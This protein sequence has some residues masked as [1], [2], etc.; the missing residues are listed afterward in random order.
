MRSGWM[1]R[2]W[3]NPY[4]A[5]VV[6]TLG[7]GGTP[8]GTISSSGFRWIKHVDLSLGYDEGGFGASVGL[9]SFVDDFALSSSHGHTPRVNRI[10]NITSFNVLGAAFGSLLALLVTDRNGRIRSW[11]FGGLLWASGLLIQIFSSDIYGLMLFAR[12]WS[13]L[14]AGLLT[15][16]T[17]LYLSEVAP[18]RTRGSVTNLYMVNLLLFLMIGRSS[19]YSPTFLRSFSFLTTTSHVRFLHQLRCTDAHDAH[20]ETISSRPSHP[21]YPDGHRILLFLLCPRNTALSHLQKTVRRRS[22]RLGATPRQIHLRSQR[23]AGSETHVLASSGKDRPRRAVELGRVQ[24]K[25]DRRQLSPTLLAPHGHA[26]GGTVDRRERYYVLRSADLPVRRGCTGTLSRWFLP[27]CMAWS[28][29]S[30]A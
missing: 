15:V 28:S 24:G 13:G 27:A 6:L 17:P 16:S 29:S 8:K 14:G 22:G 23:R 30:S 2:C 21:T 12:L 3:S 11:Q 10:A 19:N 18:A 26:D 4:F 7:L 1:R 5:F 25:P 20:S 9:P